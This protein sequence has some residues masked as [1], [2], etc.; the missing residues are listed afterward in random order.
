VAEALRGPCVRARPLL[1]TALLLAAPLAAD[2]RGD[3]LRA[4][5]RT[6]SDALVKAGFNLTRGFS[7]GGP[8]EGVLRMTL[9]VPPHEGEHVMSVWWGTEH[10]EVSLK[11]REPGGGLV[12][13]LQGRSA[14]A[15]LSVALSTGPHVLELDRSKANGGQAL[16]GVKGPVIAPCRAREVDVEEIPPDPSKKFFWPYVLALPRQARSG[17]L[18]VAPNNTGFA[19]EDLDLLRGSA[20]C[21]VAREAPL[22]VRLGTPL[23]VPLFPRPAVGGDEENLYLHALS[24][25]ALATKAP[26]YRRVDLQLLAMLDDARARLAANGIETDAKALLTGFSASASFVSRF[27]LLHPDRVKAVAAGSPGGWPIA[28]VGKD[29]DDLL[30]YPVGVADLEKLADRKFDAKAARSVSFFFF[31]GGDDENDSVPYRDSFSKDDEALVVRR[32]G[33]KPVER[34]KGAERL[35]RAAGQDARFALHPGAGHEVTPAMEEDVAR[36]F[37]GALARKR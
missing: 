32:F 23:L 28:P 19:T 3:A 6:R 8:G 1:A 5:A 16:V 35:W 21:G 25:A 18:L 22:A 26:A 9:L 15:T 17:S 7:L 27:A 31:L 14:D 2:E 12:A 36:F 10:G 24:R 4:E 20:S 33:K 11:V 30:P 13:A 37:E 34:W 29:G